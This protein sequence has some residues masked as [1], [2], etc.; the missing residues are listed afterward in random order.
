VIR[1]LAVTGGTGFVGKRFVDLALAEG[2]TVRALARSPQLV[3]DGIQ[4]ISGGLH[5]LAS[6]TELVAG[7]DAIIHI[8]GAVNAPDRNAFAWANIAGTQAVIDAAMTAG[9][10]RFVHVSSLAARES[11]LSNYGWSK[12]GAEDAVKASGLDW[13]MVR[14]PGIYGPGDRDQLDLFKAARLGV[15]PLPPAGRLSLLHVDD[16]ARLLLRLVEPDAPSGMIYEADDGREGGW[17]HIE[18]ARAIANAV[19]RKALMLALPAAMIRFGAKAD[20]LLRGKNAKLTAD[21]A[22][23]FCHPNWVIDP[24]ARSPAALWTPQIETMTGLCDT[25]RWYTQAGW[26]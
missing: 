17:S 3:R 2:W 26:L 25:A 16:L 11:G 12:V 6:L 20:R 10:A 22:A 19:G 14:P 13:V 21:R 1:T 9:V 15:M 8:A 24:S 7:T 4:W 23:Y 5:D 18:Y